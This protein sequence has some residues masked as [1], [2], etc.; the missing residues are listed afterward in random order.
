VRRIVAAI[1]RDDDVL[2]RAQ[3][4]GIDVQRV[5]PAELARLAPDGPSKGVLAF[6]DPPAPVELDDLIESVLASPRGA[7]V[8]LDGVLD[9]HNLGAIVRSAEFFGGKG[10]FWARDHSAPL[11]PAAVRA[12]A[13]ASERLPHAIVTNLARALQTC[14]DRGL[15]VV[16]TV[17]DGGRPLA[18]VV[19]TLADH[20]V[21]VFGGEEDGLR[22]L[23][24]EHCDHLVTIPKHGAIA[25]LNVS[26]A[27]A[28]V[29]AA[30]A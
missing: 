22:R 18:E 5:A 28:V 11:S 10:A 21:V 17:A 8:A 19:P 14:R 24:R 27:A 2:A 12:S 15:W 23:T 26:A 20:L 30:L 7:I 13:G 3:S 1:G 16:G 29:L 6:A 4:L 9:P 25:S